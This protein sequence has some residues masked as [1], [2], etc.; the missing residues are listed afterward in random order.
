MVTS[1]GFISQNRLPGCVLDPE[2]GVLGKYPEDYELFVAFS[3]FLLS[4]MNLFGRNFVCHDSF[5]CVIVPV[6][7]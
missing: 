4:L 1:T 3:C 6:Y 2:G 7:S 5:P